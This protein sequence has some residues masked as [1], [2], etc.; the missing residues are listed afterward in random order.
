[1]P[2]TATRGMLFGRCVKLLC[3][4]GARSSSLSPSVAVWTK[5]LRTPAAATFTPGQ[6]RAVRT[7]VTGKLVRNGEDKKAVICIEGNIASGKTTCLE[8]FSK[9]SNIEVLTEPVSKWRNVRG[10]NPLAL[11]YQDPE[12]WGIT[13]Q[14]YVQLTMLDRHLSSIAAP[15]RMMERSIFSAKYIFVENLYRSG[16]MPEVDYAVLSEWFDWITTNISIPVDLI[17]YLQTSPETCH[18]RLKQ[19]CR[20]EEKVIPLEYLESI[21]QLYEDWL[22][23]RTS[24][25][26]PAP[27]LV[28]PADHDLQKMLHHYEENR[29]KILSASY[30]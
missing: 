3:A 20:E 13:L 10:H 26:L 27:V 9:T 25:P 12:R 1:M 19:R 29:E 21:H 24:A 7:A 28:I 14:T 18:E 8:Y 11:M 5:G 30:L 16:K 23:K 17:V 22:I 2:G 15:I 4:H 6:S